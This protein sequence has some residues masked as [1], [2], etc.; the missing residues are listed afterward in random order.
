MA[1][2]T[3]EIL[4]I[5]RARDEASR[6]LRGLSHNL[7]SLDADAA[8]AA[9]Q[10]IARGQA[11]TSLGA[12]LVILGGGA[13]FVAKQA[14][15]AA[16]E[17][18][19]QAAKTLT[20][21]DN[22][23]TSLDEIKDIGIDV[24]RAV[25]VAFEEIQDALYD[26]FSSID[27]NVPEARVLLTAFSKAAVAGQTD[28][29]T[30]SRATIAILN[31][32]GLEVKDVHRVNDVMF[33]LVR[34]GV[35]TYEEFAKTI[36]RAI[37]STARA[38]Q[39]IETLAGMLAFLTRNGLSTAMAATSAAR[40]LDAM[41]H[42][43]T[44]QK[45]EKIGIA[46]KDAN[47]EF[48]PMVDILG[49]INQKIKDMPAPERAKFLFDLF[50]G[51]GGTIQARR[52]FDMVF[53]NF[54]EFEQRVGEME[55]STGAMGEAFG[56]MTDTTAVKLQELKNEFQAAKILLGDAFIDAFAEP[57]SQLVGWIE[58]LLNAFN[59]LSPA[60]KEMIG[61]V[62]VFGGALLVLV[63]IVVAVAGVWLLFMAAI[64]LA[65]T[66]LGAVAAGIGIVIG[67]IVALIAIGYLL[68]KNWDTIK[69]AAAAVWDWIK[70][71]IQAFLDWWNN[72]LIPFLQPVI[73]QLKLLW[74]EVKTTAQEAWNTLKSAIQDAW[75][76]IVEGA[77]NF[78]DSMKGVRDE[79]GKFVAFI[80]TKW[81]EIAPH[82]QKVLTVVIGLIRTA[83]NILKPIIQAIVSVFSTAFRVIGEVVK[84]TFTTIGTVIKS[85]V[86]VILNIIK[87]FVQV[88][89]G[90]FKGAGNTLKNIWK[91]I[92]SAV[93]SIFRGGVSNMQAVVRGGVNA[94]GSII[95]S[96][97]SVFYN[98]GRQ[99]MHGLLNGLRSAF[100]AVTSFV[101]GIASRIASLKGPLPKDRRLLIPAGR[102]IIQ[103][104]R[105]GLV[106]EMSNAERLLTRFTSDLSPVVVAGA[107]A[108]VPSYQPT[109]ARSSESSVINITVNTQEIDPVAHATELGYELARRL[110]M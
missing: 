87:F 35:G 4:L 96:I 91:G 64:A 14:T 68:I 39:S 73:E 17:Y 26:I 71:K 80:K 95:R 5:I 69:A 38:G 104:L 65:G 66:T 54:D 56:I 42:P 16:I 72:S 36:G 20:Q 100:G 92:W 75:D 25:P 110:G 102:A 7:R 62:I 84:N 6:T 28:L 93:I 83:F 57:L 88:I 82:V 24:G 85:A 105:E 33:Q 44:V 10:N 78:W 79:F 34:K 29:Q 22:V 101:S 1:L 3:R 55:N 74:E 67:V 46:T 86:S 30:A 11:L 23:K 97:Q 58:K 40:A 27:V 81:D 37:P 13:L 52:F 61:R 49:D 48:R 19:K 8:A 50:K 32:F 59:N 108:Q 94:I 47:G 53:T 106:D 109:M 12:G 9:Q 89:T 99:A 77:K 76:D 60:T 31:A 45:L 70:A 107:G 2:G 15:S 103:G 21:T 41:S 63:G 98:A 18:E 51:S 43:K 90:D